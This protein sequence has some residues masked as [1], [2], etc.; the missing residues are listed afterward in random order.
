MTELTE[1]NIK[2]IDK[3]GD[4]FGKRFHTQVSK[5]KMRKIYAEVKR[6]ETTFEQDNA[7][8]AIKQLVLLK[9]Q[10]KY[11]VAKDDD[12]KRFVNDVTRWIEGTSRGHL[13]IEERPGLDVGH[14]GDIGS[15]TEQGQ[16]E[17]LRAFFELMEA[18][19]AYHAYENEVNS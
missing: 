5:T 18:V 14:V 15:D 6:A 16:D 13:D 19:V 4:K 3:L 9:A 2:N 11:Q 8:E 7:E 10:L 12:L 1:D 17:A